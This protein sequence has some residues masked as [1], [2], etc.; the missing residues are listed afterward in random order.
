MLGVQLSTVRY[1]AQLWSV[2][3]KVRPY[4]SGI[5]T[6][7]PHRIVAVCVALVLGSV[8]TLAQQFGDWRT[9]FGMG[10][11]EFSV[12]NGPGNEFTISCNGRA[13]AD[14]AEGEISISIRDKGPSNP[15]GIKVVLDA[16]EFDGPFTTQCQSC[17][18]HFRALVQKLPRAKSMLVQFSDGR[19]S[20][21]SLK[22]VAQ[23]LRAGEC[24]AAGRVK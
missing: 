7:A 23:A 9:G 19:S 16:E 14:G 18:S 11:F 21:F 2:A 4:D 24:P 6:L 12:Q 1:R 15:N 13:H 10:V 8:P 5:G 22:G 17:S 3:Q 20:S